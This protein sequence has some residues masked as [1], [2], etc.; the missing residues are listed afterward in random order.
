MLVSSLCFNKMPCLFDSKYN[1]ILYE[2]EPSQN[3]PSIFIKTRTD[4]SKAFI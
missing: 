1:S 4:V 3:P 2:E